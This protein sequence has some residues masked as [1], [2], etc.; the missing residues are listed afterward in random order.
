MNSFTWWLFGYLC[1]GVAAIPTALIMFRR[2]RNAAVGAAVD[3][4]TAYLRAQINDMSTELESAREARDRYFE[5]IQGI[6]RERD[7]WMDLQR[8]ESIGHGHAQDLMM[9]TIDS[10]GRQVQSAR[11]CSCGADVPGRA[12]RIPAVLQ[13]VREEFH[14]KFEGPAQRS[15]PVP[16]PGP[17]KPS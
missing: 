11:K 9:T 13:A 1:A 2:Y 14:E 17:S 5:K 8:R 3:T 4:A 15:E 16:V 7:A 6:G 10:L 12:P